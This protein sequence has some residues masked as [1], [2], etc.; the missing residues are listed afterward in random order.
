LL[1][2]VTEVHAASET[3]V[4]NYFTRQYIPEDNSELHTCRRENLKSHKDYSRMLLGVRRST[5]Q[6][7]L[8]YDNFNTSWILGTQTL[9]GYPMFLSV[10]EPVGARVDKGLRQEEAEQVEP[11]EEQDDVKEVHKKRRTLSA[12]EPAVIDDVSV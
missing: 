10:K 3:L 2:D 6:R 12:L 4:N 5:R 9:R 7:K 11:G 8:I 1:T